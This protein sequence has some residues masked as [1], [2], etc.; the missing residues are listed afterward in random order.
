[1]AALFGV[2]GAL[3]AEPVNQADQAFADRHDRL[4]TGLHDHGGQLDR[5][6]LLPSMRRTG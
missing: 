1:V 6:R 4:R 3:P 2:G 5:Y